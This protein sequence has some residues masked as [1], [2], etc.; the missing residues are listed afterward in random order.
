MCDK[1]V[2]IRMQVIE[3]A[4]AAQPESS[5]KI[6]HVKKTDH[7]KDGKIA[8]VAS[9][10]SVVKKCILILC[11]GAHQLADCSKFKGFSVDERYNVV[12]TYRLCLVCFGEGH[13]SFKC[14]SACSVCKR[15]HHALLHR[16]PEPKKTIQC[17]NYV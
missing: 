10:K 11:S 1:V 5:S 15:R 4:G 2:K 13:M 16:D 7:R 6:A 14:S 17:H 3:N 12:C 9:N 8:L